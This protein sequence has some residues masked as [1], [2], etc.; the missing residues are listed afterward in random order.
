MGQV[1][2]KGEALDQALMPNE[3]NYIF[4]KTLDADFLQCCTHVAWCTLGLT[5]LQHT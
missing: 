4:S 2:S 1:G 3:S 5:V